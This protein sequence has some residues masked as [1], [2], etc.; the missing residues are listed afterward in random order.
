MDP[1]INDDEDDKYDF[2]ITDTMISQT[3]YQIKRYLH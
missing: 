3:N 1:V 2:L